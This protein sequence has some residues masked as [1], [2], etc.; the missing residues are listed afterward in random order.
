MLGVMAHDETLAARVRQVLAGRDGLVERRMFGG[1]A[2]LVGGNMACGVMGE[3]VVVRLGP[4]DAP[5]ALEREPHARPFGRPGARPMKGFVL[6]EAEGIADEG[7]LGR[8][9]D[10]GAAFAATLPPK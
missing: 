7:E 9:V 4:E 2:W 6:I 3:D 5:A 1:V 10:A 8:W